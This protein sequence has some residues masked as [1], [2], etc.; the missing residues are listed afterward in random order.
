MKE[1][2]VNLR[3][4][5]TKISF[6]SQFTMNQRKEKIIVR[7]F[8]ILLCFG[9]WSC[10]NEKSW[11]YK[12]WHNTLAHY[13][14][15]FN[16]EQKWLET[17]EISREA[18]KDDFRKPIDLFN[19]G[20]LEALQ[21]NQSAMDDV[22]KRTSTMIDRHPK[23]KWVDDAYHLMGKAYLL[24]GD[25]NAALDLFD[26]VATQYKDPEMQF[27]NKLWTVRALLLKGK[28][29]EAE[30]AV[31]SILANKELPIK[32]LPMAN[33]T[34]GAIYHK[35][36][37]Y[38]QSSELLEKALPFIS[39]RMD[40]YRTFFALGQAYQ[41][42]ED[43][44]KAE[45]YYAKIPRF[46]PPYEISFN[47]QISRVEIL[48]VNQKNYTK[49]NNVLLAML[50]DDKNI[51]Y[52]GQIYYRIAKN[53]LNAG[54]RNQAIEKFKISIYHSKNDP[55]QKT[56]SYLSI[57]D[58]HYNQK[59]YDMAGIYYDSANQSIDDKH[60]DFDAILAK[61]EIFGDLLKN[62]ILIK[63]N[64]SLIRMAND[65]DW[66]KVK[67]KEAIQREKLAETKSKL[68]QPKAPNTITMPG[69]PDGG[70]GNSNTNSSFPFYNMIT[71]SKGEQEFVKTWGKRENKD[72]WRLISKKQGS[73]VTNNNQADTSTNSKEKRFDSSLLVN[74]PQEEKRFYA[75]LPLTANSQEEKLKE[76]ETSLFRTAEIYQ[77]RLNEN[78]Q[79][80][81][82]YKTLVERFPSSNLCA[83]AYY[84]LIK[85][86]RLV[87]NEA[88]AEIYQSL[89]RNRFPSS[90][91]IKLLDNPNA[92]KTENTDKIKGSKEIVEFYDS[93]IR[94]YHK[95]QFIEA[96]KIKLGADKM[97]AGNSLQPRFDFVFA[98]CCAKLN[99]PKAMSYF[100]QITQDYPNT[101][102]S[103]RSHSIL[104][105]EKK[106]NIAINTPKDSV[107]NSDPNTFEVHNG[108]TPVN[109]ILV[110]PKGSNIN[111]IKANVSD[112]NKKE[113]SLE[114]IEVGTSVNIGSKYIIIIQ[115]F[116]T[117]DK[118][119]FY[120]QYLSK[121]TDFFATKGVF[122]FDV[123]WITEKNLK[124]ML[125]NLTLVDYLKLFKEGKI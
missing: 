89:L 103:E 33:F 82:Y 108:K 86:F 104:N 69:N 11:F 70:F 120:E 119:K 110:L 24:K 125:S 101:D 3:N 8:C 54:K 66:R 50:K 56:T 55:S 83:Q 100:E 39:D 81:S 93:M 107:V 44:D 7:G 74:V 14:T 64:D 26:Y 88:D 25:A 28:I 29:I 2:F 124:I 73:V 106:K 27:T 60:P 35:Q 9:L 118:A 57:G 37:K 85:L 48:S 102:V 99:D 84:E 121:Q 65:K 45:K 71:R 16:A 96:K 12:Q 97:Y 67:I 95:G 23:S 87:F 109:C 59:Q 80:I 112:L 77:N 18:Y 43:Y 122:E 30:A 6:L 79:A 40:K 52:I 72:F 49:A 58:I 31:Q 34:L 90:I 63:T 113:F 10:K 78:N 68:P 51:D 123:A 20:T 105:I 1:Y 117:P 62:L 36:K 61:N 15:Y 4:K 92:A 114:P 111:M 42:I 53:E 38:K 41:S 5:N 115:N 13:N 91:Y 22:V 47:A 19:Y 98:L 94:S 76:I 32:L 75:Q 17:L 46:N 21:A 116:T